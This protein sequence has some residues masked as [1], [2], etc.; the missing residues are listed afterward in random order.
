MTTWNNLPFP[1]LYPIHRA[2]LSPPSY[3]FFPITTLLCPRWSFCQELTFV[4]SVSEG[5]RWEV[6]LGSEWQAKKERR[7][8][9][10]LGL[11]VNSFL[12]WELPLL[13][14]SAQR[15]PYT[16]RGSQKIFGA[17]PLPSSM[18]LLTPVPLLAS[19]Q[20]RPGGILLREVFGL[21]LSSPAHCQALRT[22]MVTTAHADD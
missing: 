11:H 14:S 12:L 8:A 9:K 13:T 5:W 20:P 19:Q 22:V 18:L 7:K 15:S 21:G 17:P 4:C 16:H 6:A 1:L 3:C 10:P 2:S